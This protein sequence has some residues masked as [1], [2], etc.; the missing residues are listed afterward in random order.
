[1]A[2]VTAMRNNGL[3]YPVYGMPWAVT[4]PI[5]DADGDPVTGATGL[6]SEVSKNGDTFADCTNE[7]TEI[8]TSSGIYYLLLTA[9][10][11]TADCVSVIV[12]TSSTGAK[13][14]ILTFYPRKL[15]QIASGTSQ[16]GDTGYITLAA[17]T[18]TF[19]NQ[20]TGC[21]CIATIDT[22]I[23]ARVLG[24]CT[25][26]NQQCAVSP[27]W[28]V[29]PDADDTYAIYLPEGMLV[30]QSNL[31]TIL[32]T[33]LTETVA[34]YLAAGVKKLLD[35]AAPV[36]T[37]ASVNQT[38]DASA[39]L[40]TPIA[41]NGGTAT[42]AGM[43]T[44]MV[45]DNGGASFVSATDS[46]NKLSTTVVA[47]TTSTVNANANTET[48][49]TLVSGTSASTYLS[50]NV[51]WTT[52]PVTP[53][54]AESGTLLSPFG[55]NVN[56][57]YTLTASQTIN[58]VT[59]RGYFQNAT[60]SARYCNV[61]AYNYAT[62]SWDMLSDSS[63]RMN[64]ATSNQP[65][66]YGLTGQH[67]K[68]DAGGDGQY[69]VRIGFKSPSV[70]TGDR[71][72]V[73][74]CVVNITTAGPSAADVAAATKAA[75]TTDIL[76]ILDRVDFQRGHH[77]VAGATYYVDGTGGSDL[78]SGTRASPKKT[79]SAALAL[80]NSNTHDEIVLLPDIAGGPTTV[81]E[82]STINVT[83][84]YVQIRGPG[85]DMVVTLTGAGNVFNITA[86]GVGMSG[87]RV[88]T[89]SGASSGVV[90]SAADFVRLERLWIESAHQD[91]V[92]LSVANNTEIVEC[93]LF[94]AARD[95]VRIDS[96]SGTGN[97][98]IVQNCVIR[99]SVGSAVNLI[100][101]DASNC[102]IQH[103]TIRGNAVGLTVGS[104]VVGTVFTDNRMIANTVPISDAGTSTLSQWNFPEPGYSGG[105]VYVKASGQSGASP[106]V[107]GTATNPCPWAD[108]V[109]IAA[110]ENISEFHILN[111]ETVSLTGDTINKTLL[112]DNWTLVLNN[113]NVSGSHF[114][115]AEVSGI[116]TTT[117]QATFERCT[118]NAGTTLGPSK[119]THA[120]FQTT[121]G[122]KFTA[123]SAGEYVFVDCYS[124]VAGS[125]APYF[126]FAGTGG[127][128]TANFRR[129]SG[130]SN[131]TLDSNC[132]ATME[133]VTGG[134]QT[135]TTGGANVEIRGIPRSVTLV[136]SGSE[137]CQFDGVT[138]P[139]NVSGAATAATVNLYGVTGLVTSTATGCTVNNLAASQATL[140]VD[141]AGVSTL[142]NRVPQ[143]IPMGQVG[144]SGPYLVQSDIKAVAEDTSA[145]TALKDAL[146]SEVG[147]TVN[148]G[149]PTVSGFITSLQPADAQFYTNQFLVF[150]S[151]TLTGQ[152]RKI[153]TCTLTGGYLTVAWATGEDA[154]TA[155]P[156]NGDGF[157]ITGRAK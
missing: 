11:M 56:L 50:N 131:I 143:V 86:N 72:N 35:V 133:V 91:A 2:E 136:V 31:T 21:L 16:G 152:A 47:G 24:A 150:T 89:V 77:T 123:G 102:R 18:V 83:K 88:A 55:L 90:V 37:L 5:L 29:A 14:T 111:G 36:F 97:Y 28:N 73:D 69:S 118:I 109:T 57:K 146:A 51:S 107:N 74:Q 126:T 52:A 101:S 38:G 17:G 80:C 49:G 64:H 53:A 3:P 147:G 96:G 157:R 117:A 13:T 124:E 119:F 105:A 67:V 110:E 48:T 59:I 99:D 43:L 27:G 129:W 100:G 98:N 71:L 134:G 108:A 61:Y 65:Y 137:T 149:S 62:S 20:F 112:G 66:T 70:T 46:L 87:F 42:I 33:S 34:G 9:T 156:A 135:I 6:D 75:M 93:K 113:R 103:N 19:N 148:D 44:K 142:L 85:R 95:G 155:A 15:I 40:G 127:T 120:G 106:G 41:L 8:A 138:G 132:T 130:G 78:N 128:T 7:A 145:A 115:G 84:N 81:T 141:S 116:G 30:H 125:G 140:N 139:I 144:G 68:P 10:E 54:V 4:F 92:Q 60:G 32:G 25:A 114:E 45:D 12:K 39:K 23:E 153:G 22:L 154:L 122:S 94:T 82:S 151:G 76:R 63:T 1:M 104:G 26:S 121:S 58:S 79:L